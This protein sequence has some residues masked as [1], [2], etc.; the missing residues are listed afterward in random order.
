MT[1]YKSWNNSYMKWD[2]KLL[3]VNHQWMNNHLTNLLPVPISSGSCQSWWSIISII[4]ISLKSQVSHSIQ[5]IM[6]QPLTWLDFSQSL[7][8]LTDSEW[9]SHVI[10][11]LTSH[12][13]SVFILYHS[14]DWVASWLDWLRVS[15]WSEPVV[16]HSQSLSLT[17]CHSVSVTQCECHWLSRVSQWLDSSSPRLI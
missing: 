12:G 10:I 3:S 14:L 15:H 11:M 6:K 2:G 8:V 16:S 9:V 4:Q 17:H 5:W 1:S 7:T 13:P